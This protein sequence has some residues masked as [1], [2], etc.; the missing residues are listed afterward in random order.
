M[1]KLLIPIALIIISCSKGEENDNVDIVEKEIVGFKYLFEKDFKSLTINSNDV[2]ITFKKFYN[3][4]SVNSPRNATTQ[5][6]EMKTHLSIDTLTIDFKGVEWSD[7]FHLYGG[8]LDANIDDEFYSFINF[9]KFVNMDKGYTKI[10][11][12][13]RDP[14]K[15]PYFNSNL[16]E[17][18]IEGLFEGS[19]SNVNNLFRKIP[20]DSTR[21]YWERETTSAYKLGEK[22]S[23]SKTWYYTD[24]V[25]AY[26]GTY[27][28]GNFVN[29][30]T[31]IKIDTIYK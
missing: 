19:N 21:L 22:L 30:Y 29:D 2:G 11:L 28:F 24:I 12:W 14:R 16:T 5:I 6:P 17:N 26:C 13:H 25:C 1:K 18:E 4:H 27:A 31:L 7:D 20:F 3:Y 23:F 10:K 8:G 15:I 9:I